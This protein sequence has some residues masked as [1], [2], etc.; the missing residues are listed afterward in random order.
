MKNTDNVSPYFSGLGLAILGL[1]VQDY[2]AAEK[3]ANEMRVLVDGYAREIL[4][5]LDLRDRDSGTLI[6]ENKWAWLAEDDKYMEYH[7]R[8]QAVCRANIPGA[9]D[10]PENYC[11]ALVTEER[12]RQLALHIMDHAGRLYGFDGRRT[13]PL[14][15]GS[16]D[17]DFFVKLLDF[18]EKQS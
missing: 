9:A 15:K 12:A 18:V 3:L 2:R 1:Q 10:L 16:I 5:D 7:R 11:I 8:L 4:A 13:S 17:N 14:L 6:T